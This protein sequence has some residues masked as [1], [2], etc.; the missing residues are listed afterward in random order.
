MKD[1]VLFGSRARGTHDDDSDAALAV[2]LSGPTGE[3]YRIAGEM[4]EIAFT[5]MLETG[6][7]VQAVPLWKDE[8]ERPEA[9]S[10][11][12]LIAAIKRDGLRL[13]PG[14]PLLPAT[15]RKPSERRDRPGCFSRPAISMARA[16]VRTTRCSMRPRQHCWLRGMLSPGPE[17]R[18]IAA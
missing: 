5:V 6:V 8:F 13:C 10:N 3:R 2:I 15:C 17:A 11:P 7:L 14:E 12:G 16:I 4:A 18:P 9:F 1:V